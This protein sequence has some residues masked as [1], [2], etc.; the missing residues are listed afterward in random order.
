MWLCNTT[1]A[2]NFLIIQ[3]ILGRLFWSTFEGTSSVMWQTVNIRKAY[4]VCSYIPMIAISY[5][6][7]AIWV[8]MFTCRKSCWQCKPNLWSWSPLSTTWVSWKMGF[9]A[10][11]K[12]ILVG[13]TQSSSF[14]QFQFRWMK[15]T[16]QTISIRLIDAKIKNQ[17]SLTQPSFN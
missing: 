13:I 5:K 17:F 15:D 7:W 3:I 2:V 12:S 14:K 4:M 1:P 16:R 11:I 10:L 6:Y 8:L 9:K